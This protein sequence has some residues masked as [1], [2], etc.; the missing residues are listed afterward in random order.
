MPTDRA[1]ALFPARFHDYRDLPGDAFYR[2]LIVFGFAVVLYLSWRFDIFH[3]V[4]SAARHHQWGRFV[5][6]PAILWTGMGMLMLL[7]RTLLWFGYRTPPIATIESA[8][9]LTVIIPAYNEGEMVARSIE[10]VVRARYPRGRLE[11]FVVD[12]G[13]VDDTWQHIERIAR[14]YPDIVT[15]L[16]FERKRLRAPSPGRSASAS[17]PISIRLCRGGSSRCRKPST[18]LPAQGR[19]SS[20]A[21]RI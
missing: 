13:S 15:A 6:S 18:S 9:P 17:T 11:V 3:G 2:A 16:R 4:V 5:V 12:D 8:P 21:R 20:I 10:S 1:A 19:R 7:L 14:R